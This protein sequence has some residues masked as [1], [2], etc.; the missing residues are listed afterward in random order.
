[1]RNSVYARFESLICPAPGGESSGYPRIGTC[2]AHNGMT[3]G[4][5]TG[6]PLQFLKDIEERRRCP[7]GEPPYYTYDLRGEPFYMD[8]VGRG[9][10]E[11]CRGR[12]R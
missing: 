1:M 8:E 2:E 11:V 6:A 5:R 7:L 4:S 12:S 10:E 9:T 3:K